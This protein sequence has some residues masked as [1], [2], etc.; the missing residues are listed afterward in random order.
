MLVKNDIT[1]L[2][3]RV[4]QSQELTE[5]ITGLASDVF[6]V[7]GDM[8]WALSKISDLISLWQ[9]DRKRLDQAAR[10]VAELQRRVAALEEQMAADDD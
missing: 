10:V 1:P 5:T 8:A 9:E 7:E 2:P 3:R 6:Q 4:P